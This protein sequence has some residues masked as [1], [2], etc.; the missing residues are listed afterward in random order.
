M[1]YKRRIDTIPT[2]HESVENIAL[3]RNPNI[4]RDELLWR[5]DDCLEWVCEHGVGH[6]IFAP[7]PGP[8]WYH[9]CDGCCNKIKVSFA[10][11]FLVKK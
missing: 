4:K 2:V 7:Y 3:R 5:G 1:K 9:G 8:N 11:E 6:T 10:I